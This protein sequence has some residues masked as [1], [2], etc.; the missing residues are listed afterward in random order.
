MLILLFSKSNLNILLVNKSIRYALTEPRP[1]IPTTNAALTLKEDFEHWN[2]SNNK[3]KAYMLTSM[4][5]ALR[6]K[7]ENKE[8]A[9]EILDTLQEMFRMQNNQA[10]IEDTR[11]YMNTKAPM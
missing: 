9:V 8:T 3:A 5:D 6:T 10:R 2:S 11:K 4:S 7:L 1:P